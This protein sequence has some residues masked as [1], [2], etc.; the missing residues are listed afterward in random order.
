M[1]DELVTHD[2]QDL[3]AMMRAQLG[4][5]GLLVAGGRER[6][7]EVMD[8]STGL[9]WMS[10]APVEMADF[11]ALELEPPWVKVGIA[12][13]S[14]DRAAFLYSPGAPKAPVGERQIGGRRFI[15]VAAPREQKAAA[16]AGGPLEISVDKAHLIGFEAG[17]ELAVLSLPQGNF[18]EVVGEAENDASLVLPEAGS[19]R[20]ITLDRPWVLRL[21]TPTTTFFWIA[22]SMRS[23]QGPVVLPQ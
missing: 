11:D 23:F 7:M 20:R 19:L 1:E 12:R 17:R 10:A 15:K 4:E 3:E 18:V 8:G 9:V 14:M 16:R 6:Y 22:E 13:A 21:P 2:K 5:R